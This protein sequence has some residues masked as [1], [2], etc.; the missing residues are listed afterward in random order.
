MNNK[1]SLSDGEWKLMNL[2]WDAAPEP[3][4]IG[5]MVEALRDDTAWTKATVNIMLTRLSDKGAVRITTGG[6]SKRF[7]P[8]LTRSDAVK[9]EAKNTLAKIRTGGLGLLV[10]TM[11]ADCALSD[12]EI[13]EL[14]RILK[15][16][17]GGNV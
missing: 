3:L 12:D 1:I 10:S 5:E 14:Y 4:T 6:R 11:A 17:R 15:Q 13:D 7:Y 9:Q 2:L 8:M 16:G